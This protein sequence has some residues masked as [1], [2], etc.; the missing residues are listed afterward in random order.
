MTP[1]H[2]RR[3]LYV[4]AMVNI[5]AGF[6]HKGAGINKHF[7]KNR[8]KISTLQDKSTVKYRKGAS[9]HHRTRVA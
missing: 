8:A 4:Q 3:S 5:L 2:L 6:A 7:P 9:L 1:V